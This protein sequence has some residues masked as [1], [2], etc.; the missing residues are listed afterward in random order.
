L[1]SSRHPARCAFQGNHRVSESGFCRAGARLHL[2]AEVLGN[3]AIAK[4]KEAV[5]VVSG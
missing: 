2:E 3:F 4:I 1:S 5:L